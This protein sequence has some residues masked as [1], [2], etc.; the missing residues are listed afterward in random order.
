VGRS[1]AKVGNHIPPP[2]T[3]LGSAESNRSVN[4]IGARELIPHE[5][6]L[7]IIALKLFLFNPFPIGYL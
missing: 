3:G 5:Y 2:M 4:R 1:L 6:L 7:L